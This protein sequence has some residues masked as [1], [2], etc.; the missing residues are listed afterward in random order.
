MVLQHEP[1]RVPPLLL[2]PGCAALEPRVP[3]LERPDRV[4]GEDVFAQLRHLDGAVV[5]RVPVPGPVLITLL[6]QGKISAG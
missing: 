2:L 3:D 5:L 4:V 1:L 6:L